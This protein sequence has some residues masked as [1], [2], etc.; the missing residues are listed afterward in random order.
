MC[1]N[2]NNSLH[3]NWN[4]V[5]TLIIQRNMN[6]NINALYQKDEYFSN[7]D[8]TLYVTLTSLYKKLCFTV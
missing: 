4:T 7:T 8:F 5:M 2:A 1:V 3:F 6:M